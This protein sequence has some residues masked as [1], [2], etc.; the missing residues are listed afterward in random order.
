MLGVLLFLFVL[1]FLLRDARRHRAQARRREGAARG[2]RAVEAR[3]TATTSRAS[4]TRSAPR[5]TMLVDHFRRMLTFDFGRSDADDTPIAQRLRERRR[6]RASPSRVPLFVLGL[7]LGVGLALF[8]AFFR[9]TYIDRVGRRARRARD[10]RLDPAL[11]HRRASTCSGSCCAGSRSRASTRRPRVI[12]RF[13]A[14]PRDR[15]PAAPGSAATCAS[16]APSSSRR[17]AATTCAPRA[18]RAA[19]RAASWCATCCATR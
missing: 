15:R 8:V 6:A 16:T 5:D 18:P 14:L 12:A 3:T 4:G 10:E 9:D 2:A 17:R 1:F 11:H 7:V 13:L 19:A